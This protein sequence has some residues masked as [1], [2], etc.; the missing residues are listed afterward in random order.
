[1][2]MT[3][4]DRAARTEILLVDDDVPLGRSIADLLRRH[5]YTVDLVHDGRAAMDYVTRQRVALVISDIFMPE[6]DGLELLGLLRRCVPCPLLVAMSGSGT[7]RVNGMLKAAKMLGAVRTLAKP[8]ETTQL[9]S[10]VQE[11]IGPPA[12]VTASAGPRGPAVQ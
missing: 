6:A 2:P 10:L 12:G 1:M 9:I 11:L 5:G 3:A 7:Y 4:P 8:F